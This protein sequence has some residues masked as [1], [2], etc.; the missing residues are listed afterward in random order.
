LW[1]SD[2]VTWT[3]VGNITGP[4]G[5]TGPTGPTGPPGTAGATGPPGSTGATGP[6]GTTGA[7]GPTGPT[8]ATGA[9]GA[10]GAPGATGPSGSPGATG[11]GVATGGTTGQILSKLSATNFD[12]GWTNVGAAGTAVG[13]TFTPAAGIAATDVQAALVELAGDVTSLPLLTTSDTSKVPVTTT[14]GFT[15]LD[16]TNLIATSSPQISIWTPQYAIATSDVT[17][18]SDAAANNDTQLLLPVAANAVY[19]LSLVL[20]YEGATNTSDFRLGFNAPTGATM[21]WRTSGVH[22]SITTL[23]T[24]YQVTQINT[25]ANTQL[26]ATFAAGNVMSAHVTAILQMSTTAG[27]LNFKWGQGVSEAVNT[28]RKTGSYMVLHRLA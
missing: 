17:K 22:N 27:N 24:Q 11:P 6:T 7:T 26:I 8:G 19:E 20:Y 16:V 21:N 18:S 25:L 10:A 3:D 28:I 1:V 14:T 12:T 23:T 5:P 2:H 15:T 4:A 9:T 13:T